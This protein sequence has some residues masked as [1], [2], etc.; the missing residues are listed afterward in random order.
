MRFVFVA[1][2]MSLI[3]M[4]ITNA[5][6]AG[7]TPDQMCGWKIVCDSNAAPSERYAAEQFQLLFKGLTGTELAVVTSLTVGEGAILIGPDAASKAGLP[8]I[9]KGVD[10]ETLR[11]QVDQRSVAIDG[12]R[13][14]GT[15][16]GVYEFFEELCGVR[17]LTFDDTYYPPDA[18]SKV[19]ALGTRQ[20]TP[21][22]AFR[23]SYYGETNQNPEF[24]ARLHT[25]T[26]TD[27]PEL[28]GITGYHLVN[29][30]V[31]YLVPP[32]VYGKSHPEYYAEVNGKRIWDTTDGGGPQL[33]LTNPKVRDVLAAA[34]E[35]E[36]QKNPDQRNFNIAQMDNA[37]Y[38]TCPNCKALDD[39]EGSHAGTMIAFVNSVAEIVEKKH[40]NV[41]LSTFAYWYTRKPP[42]TIRP[43]HN[44]MVQLCSI[45]CCTLHAID[46]PSCALNRE[47][48]HDMKVWNRLCDKLFIWHYNTNFSAYTLPFP[49]LRSIGKS[50]S[51]FAKHSGRGVFMQA[52]G[53]G[54]STEMSDLRN[55]VMSRCLW[56]PGRD[57]WAEAIEFCKLHYRES[58]DPII[59]YLTD[60]HDRVQA[61]GAHPTCFSTESTLCVT[62][63]SAR[64]MMAYFNEAIS[65]AKSD[66]VRDRVEKAS[67]CVNRAALSGSSIDLVYADDVCKPD[68]TGLD[69]NLL[70]TYVA[71]CKKFGVTMESEGISTE[72]YISGIRN[73]YGGLK[74]VRI[75]NKTWRIVLLPGSNGKL[76]E[77]TY[78]PTG[79][80][81][82]KP[83]RAFNR[84]RYEEWVRSGH[85]PSGSQL[86]SYEVANLQPDSVS[87]SLTARDGT[88][89]E[90][91]ISLS[92]DAVHFDTEITAGV[93]RS[94]DLWVHP[95]YDAGTS[96]ADPQTVQI[97]VKQGDKL[98]H[99]NKGWKNALSNPAQEAKV[100]ESA[101]FGYFA[102]FNDELKYGVEERFAP[103]QFRE[104]ALFW[105]ISRQQVN[106]ELIPRVMSL[107]R[108][109]KT[110]YGYE[111]RYL[112][113]KPGEQ[114][115]GKRD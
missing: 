72:S 66:V 77:M 83:H 44:V 39:R 43:R 65:L 38:C 29:H 13:P 3:S 15:L 103:D 73:F 90:R 2:A 16:Y 41:L 62:P 64:R 86:L 93:D 51:Y 79:R 92:S 107:A 101:R 113:E 84:F 61:A 114:G 87:L 46:D 97:Y 28:G 63:D 5:R 100:R 55:Y 96:S 7:L 48:C 60:L 12:G 108:G 21:K 31:A 75:E 105:G 50:V 99:A 98:L 71:M 78:K 109:E 74:A 24:A 49:N 27:K 36:I 33:C 104:L 37:N 89:F 17:Y 56:K 45:E 85:G 34:I 47:F 40:P 6:A 32:A 14:R 82:I 9:G 94:L 30:C 19:I 68:L 115:I 4:M 23:W 53:N 42:K 106:L 88:K 52:A 57:S 81:L 112:A 102:M 20:F 67:L 22:F 95:E 25:N 80:N 8:P 26:V 58:A 70:D 11:I 59:A 110:H 18:H 1:L 10:E 76:V 35:E 91:K 54:F 111:V 69:P